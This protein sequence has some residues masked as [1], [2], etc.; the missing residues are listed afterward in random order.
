M[1]EKE[2]GRK[3]G[4]RPSKEEAP[5]PSQ[6]GKEE[7]HHQKKIKISSSG[8]GAP[9]PWGTNTLKALVM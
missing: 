6:P 8:P 5:L 3:D 1:G 4:K 9:N 7:Q 2:E